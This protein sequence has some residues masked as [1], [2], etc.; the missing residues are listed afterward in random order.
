[1]GGAGSP[2]LVYGLFMLGG[3]LVGAAWSAR[4]QGAKPLSIILG[5]MA[6]VA[7]CGGVLWGVDLAR[8]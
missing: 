6:A 4:N 8:H 5:V 3:L 1:M 2:L 7:V